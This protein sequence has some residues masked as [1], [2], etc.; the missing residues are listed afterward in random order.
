MKCFILTLL[1]PITT[2]LGASE[3][4]IENKVLNHKK[5]IPQRVKAMPFVS[6][7]ALIPGLG[8]SLRNTKAEITTSMHTLDP[9]KFMILSS[10]VSYLTYWTD[11][12]DELFHLSK[13]RTLSSWKDSP[14]RAYMALGLGG[15]TK[16]NS[17]YSFSLD[18]FSGK[19]FSGKGFIEAPIRYGYE[20]ANS[21]FDIGFTMVYGFKET[22]MIYPV[23]QIRSG[24]SF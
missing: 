19:G 10:T 5:D 18:S 16:I 21:F 13:K 7:V 23:P 9:M 20:F 14:K 15:G 11:I 1:I 24:I 22:N 2:F 8:I 3:G 4:Q 6:L 17:R 12:P